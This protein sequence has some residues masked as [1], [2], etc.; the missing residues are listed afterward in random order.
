[1][2]IFSNGC[3]APG[4][5]LGRV[6]LSGMIIDNDKPND[7]RIRVV[8]PETYGL[9]GLD[10]VF[11]K[12]SDYGNVDLFGASTIDSKGE[13][14]ILLNPTVYHAAFWLVP[15][16]GFQPKYPPDPYFAIQFSNAPQQI[17]LVQKKWGKIKYEVWTMPEKKELKVEDAFWHIVNGSIEETE[18]DFEGKKLKGKIMKIE[19]SKQKSNE[20]LQ[21]TRD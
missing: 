11:G 16:L 12:P 20:S 7:L 3:A 21:R 18:F 1:M 4:S 17:Y 5:A 2:I 13:F 14:N 10:R 9:G 6:G 15:P 8:L 19:I